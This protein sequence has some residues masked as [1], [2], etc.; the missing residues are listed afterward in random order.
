[1]TLPIYVQN[2]ESVQLDPK[3]HFAYVEFIQSGKSHEEASLYQRL[4]GRH[5]QSDGMDNA[6][7]SHFWSFQVNED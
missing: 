2:H 4:K 5:A 6:A 7:A 3:R 1:L